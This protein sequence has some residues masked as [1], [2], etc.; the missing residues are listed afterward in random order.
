MSTTT[1]PVT[2]CA[3]ATRPTTSSICLVDSL[4]VPL[5]FGRVGPPLAWGVPPA[6]Q[7]AGKLLVGVHHVDADA[8]A[9]D[10]GD[11][12]AQCGSGPATPA[13]DFAEVVGVH[14]HL[15]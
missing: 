10:S 9:A 4:V 13:D 5:P 12:R 15:D 2:P 7:P 14:M 11:Q 6:L 8:T 1:S 3:L